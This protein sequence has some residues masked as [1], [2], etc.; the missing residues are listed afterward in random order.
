MQ[1]VADI[2]IVPVPNAIYHEDLARRLHVEADVEGTRSRLCC[3]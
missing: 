2:N 3:G 1:E